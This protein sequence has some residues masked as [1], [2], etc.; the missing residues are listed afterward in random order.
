MTRE[1]AGRL[2]AGLSKEEK[3]KLL[4]LLLLMKVEREQKGTQ[5]KSE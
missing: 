5:L 2:I 1:E 3:L 4:K